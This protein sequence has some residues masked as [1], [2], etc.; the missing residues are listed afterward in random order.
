MQRSFFLA[1][2]V[3]VDAHEAAG[4][5]HHFSEADEKG[6][7]DLSPGVNEDAAEEHCQTSNGEDR[8]R[9][10]LYVDVCFHCPTDLTDLTDFLFDGAKVV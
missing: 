7:V 6:L 2:I 5:G 8:C 4:E 1:P 3:I 9:D 10:E